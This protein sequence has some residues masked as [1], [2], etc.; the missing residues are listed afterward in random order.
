MLKSHTESTRQQFLEILHIAAHD[1]RGPLGS[2]LHGLELLLDPRIGE[3]NEKQRNIVL[4]LHKQN[5]AL[6]KIL[7]EVLDL[8][9]ME[10]GQLSIQKVPAIFSHIL[11][12]TLGEMV[13]QAHFAQVQ[14]QLHD[15][16]PPAFV[17]EVD[18]ARI[19]QVLRNLLENALRYSPKHHTLSIAAAVENGQLVISCQNNGP[20][21]PA[22]NIS[23]IF[24]K[25]FQVQHQKK[26][27]HGLGLSICRNIVE[28]HGGKIW[29]ENVQPQ[30]VKFTFVLPTQSAT[31]ESAATSR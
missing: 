6:H 17:I 25:F 22:E 9:K 21:I 20:H 27:G 13:E 14:L 16:L 1:I 19:R 31:V 11:E 29:A 18:V 30:G 4:S 7:S 26:L 24:D 8:E 23:Q 28:L 2:I 3:L 15:Q 12:I 10:S 5:S